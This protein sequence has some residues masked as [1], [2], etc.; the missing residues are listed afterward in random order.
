MFNYGNLKNP[1]IWTYY[2]DD[3]ALDYA[4]DQIDNSLPA[5]CF[6]SQKLK[7][8]IQYDRKNKRS[9]TKSLQIYLENNMSVA[10]TIRVLYMQR[11]TFLYH[12]KRIEEITDL[13]LNDYSTRL[14]L[15]LSFQLLKRVK[16]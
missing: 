6:C 13:D 15:Q 7:K 8:L 4:L 10:K 9:Y 16:E 1:E 14:Y 12:L 2:F 5:W 3:Y 11:Q